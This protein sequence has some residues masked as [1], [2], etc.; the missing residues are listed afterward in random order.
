MMGRT[1]SS[2]VAWESVAG[3]SDLRLA[4][5]PV[6]AHPGVDMAEAA[7]AAAHALRNS[8]LFINNLLLISK[9]PG[10]CSKASFVCRRG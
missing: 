5:S 7:A 2:N 10:V 6:I 8:R 4:G 3:C 9:T 1:F